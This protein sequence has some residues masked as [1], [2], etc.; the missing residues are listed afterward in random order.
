MID[1]QTTNLTKIE[2]TN[3]E[4][5]LKRKAYHK[6]QETKNDDSYTIFKNRMIHYNLKIVTYGQQSSK[7]N[8]NK[9]L[10]MN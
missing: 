6:N 5:I 10:K 4:L 8:F 9:I 7:L 2:H 1:M 3:F